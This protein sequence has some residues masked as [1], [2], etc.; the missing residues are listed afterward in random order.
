M[1]YGDIILED[2]FNKM[3]DP[4][5]IMTEYYENEI[6]FLNSVIEYQN[7]AS[8]VTESYELESIHEGFI[9]TAKNKIK[10]LIDNFLKWV[11]DVWSKFTSVIKNK[12]GKK[13]YTL[14]SAKEAIKKIENNANLSSEDKNKK[15]LQV[16]YKLFKTKNDSDTYLPIKYNVVSL[17]SETVKHTLY[18]NYSFTGIIKDIETINLYDDDNYASKIKFSEKNL[19]YI[20]E[21]QNKVHDNI[22]S[23][24]KNKAMSAED[25]LSQYEKNL[26]EYKK[27]EIDFE[28]SKKNI[29]NN[30]NKAKYFINNRIPNDI[31]QK[32]LAHINKIMNK[33]IKLNKNQ[34]TIATQIINELST[35]IKPTVI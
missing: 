15:K 13:E 20:E 24:F 7:E 33:Y 17:D 14:E 2:Q 11:K 4:I 8:I 5:K 3:T 28:N 9:E 18:D 21:R 32:V 29:E 35:M 10:E 19:E 23:F 22:S 27:I 25:A 16:I 12:I 1:I 30:A 34:I 31:N 26:E 6:S